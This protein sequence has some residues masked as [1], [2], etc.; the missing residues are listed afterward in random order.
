[1]RKAKLALGA[2]A[3]LLLAGGTAFAQGTQGAT[4]TITVPRDAVVVVLPPGSALPALFPS[5]DA[6]FGALPF[7]PPMGTSVL[8]RQVDAMMQDMQ[9]LMATMPLPPL[10]APGTLPASW[11]HLPQGAIGQMVVTVSGPHGSCTRSV[12][13]TGTN[14]APLIETRLSG[15]AA[16]PA[17]SQSLPASLAL[18]PGRPVPVRTEP[19]AV[20]PALLWPAS[21][22]TVVPSVP[23]G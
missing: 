22:R 9:H 21:Y 23:R 10:P 12:T 13:Y 16:C 3:A 4:R 20:K 8:F 11:T 15:D 7:A 18:T 6:G 5:L 19:P 17:L 1:M 2:A 14:A